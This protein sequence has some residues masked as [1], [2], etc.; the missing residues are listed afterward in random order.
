MR[1]QTFAALV[2]SILTSAC[3]GSE[4]APPGGP[5]GGAFP[6]TDV[7]TVA[8]EPRPTPQSSEYVAT[9]RSLRSTTI[10]PQVEGIVRQIFVTAGQRV[11]A[12]APLIQIDPDRQQATV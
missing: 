10:Q 6:P 7:M 9:V 1:V 11:A 12:G 2:V 8:L 5:P 3:G 4:Q